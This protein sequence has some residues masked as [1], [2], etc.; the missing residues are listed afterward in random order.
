MMPS[1]PTLEVARESRENFPEGRVVKPLGLRAFLRFGQIV[2]GIFW[3]GLWLV[4]LAKFISH[5]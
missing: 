3:L 5:L 1:Q 2:A 4:D